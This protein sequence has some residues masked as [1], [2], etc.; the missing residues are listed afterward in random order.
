MFSRFLL[1]SLLGGAVCFA[2]PAPNTIT[3]TATRAVSVQPDQVVFNVTVTSPVTSS[4]DEV[5]AALQ[6][7]G[8]TL[9]NFTSVYSTQT[10][11]SQ[12]IGQAS[13]NQLVTVLQW[14]FTLTVP[15][16]NLKSTIDTLT[17]LQMALSTAKNGMSMGFSVQGMQASAQAQQAQPCS[18]SGLIADARAQ[19]LKIANAA[20]ATLGNI[21]AL[22]NAVADTSPVCSATV[23]FGL[24]AGF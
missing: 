4:R 21:V 12:Q 24:T 22:S 5:V 11:V 6:G 3:V 13:S 2:Q 15:L 19:A 14:N 10:V 20:S 8:I 17:G 9:A 18:L 23:T 1:V 7:S 16:A